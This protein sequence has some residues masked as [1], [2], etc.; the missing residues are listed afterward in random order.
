MSERSSDAP[1]GQD[2]ERRGPPPNP[3]HHPLFLPVLL[4]AFTLWFGFDGFVTTDPE[5]LEH[6][7]FNRIMYLVM[8]PI[9]LRAVPR[10]IAEF[11]EDQESAQATAQA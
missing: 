10:G 7:N 11:L 4:V 2:T 8:Q 5:M 1:Q 3:I 9:C 6:R